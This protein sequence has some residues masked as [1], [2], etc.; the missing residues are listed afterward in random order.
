MRRV[1][2]RNHQRFRTPGN[3]SFSGGHRAFLEP[4]EARRLLASPKLIDV[5]PLP[6]DGAVIGAAITQ[7]DIE[8]SEDLAAGGVNDDLSWQMIEAGPDDLFDTS[9][10]VSILATTNGSYSAG[11]TVILSLSPSPLQP[12]YYRFTADASLLTGTDGSPLDGNGDGTGGDDF[13]TTFHVATDPGTTIESHDNDARETADRLDMIENPSSSGHHV[14]FGLGYVDRTE[15]TVDYWWFEALAGDKIAIAVDT[16]QSSMNSYVELRDSDGGLHAQDW[17]NGPDTDAFIS[18]YTITTPGRYF[19]SVS[20]ESGEGLYDL[21]VEVVRGD[22]QL[23]TDAEYANDSI[24]GADRLVKQL[25][26]LDAVASVAAT[27]MSG[28]DEDYFSLGSLNAGNQVQLDLRLPNGSTL[29]GNVVLVDSSGTVVADDDGILTDSDYQ[30][31]LITPGAY[32]AKVE[33]NSGAGNYAQ[34]ILD[35]TIV[36]TVSPKVTGVSG[37]PAE[38]RTAHLPNGRFTVSFDEDLDPASVAAAG[39][40]DF[41]AAG[42]DDSF[43]TPDDIIYNLTQLPVYTLD[44]NVEF[45]VSNGQIIDGLYR[46]RATSLIT[47]IAGNTLDGNSDGTGGDAYEHVFSIDLPDGI[48]AGFEDEDNSALATATPLNLVEDAAVPGV[49]SGVGVG[50]VDP[51]DDADY[52]SFEAEAGDRV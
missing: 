7:L 3:K 14:G 2:S 35:V 33:D 16:P 50:V 28:D 43:D 47:D 25:S 23:E 17:N 38:G 45:D 5:S 30:A 24:A 40:F 42:E 4:L 22:L 9:D 20:S 36:D 10:D 1:R 51:S 29:D 8:F 12:G 32:Y 49:F 48:N 52:W 21:R 31:T 46:L 37:L 39:A 11:T 44:N 27:I 19:A 26:G 15:D 41:R 13:V 34:Y 6:G 18:Y